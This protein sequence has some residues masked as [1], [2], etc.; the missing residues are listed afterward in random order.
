MF[1]LRFWNRD[2]VRPILLSRLPWLTGLCIIGKRIFK[3]YSARTSHGGVRTDYKKPKHVIGILIDSEQGEQALL[4][5][6]Y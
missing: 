2:G 3:I 4:Y 6:V 5:F 1:A